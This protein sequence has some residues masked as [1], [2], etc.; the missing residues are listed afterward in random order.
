MCHESLLTYSWSKQLLVLS[1][2]HYYTS[3]GE[4][5]SH[6]IFKISTTSLNCQFY[7]IVWSYLSISLAWIFKFLTHIFELTIVFLCYVFTLIKEIIHNLNI[8]VTKTF[9]TSFKR[10]QTLIFKIIN[11]NFKLQKY[12]FLVSNLNI[13]VNNI[14]KITDQNKLKGSSEVPYVSDR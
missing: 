2:K 9:V 12:I 13:Q 1:T 6:T 5:L 10:E 11:L 8:Q 3:Y 4:S 14:I 7:L